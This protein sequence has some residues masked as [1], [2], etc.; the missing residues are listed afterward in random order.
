MEAP[1][2]LEVPSVVTD[3]SPGQH[4]GQAA[5]VSFGQPSETSAMPRS[6]A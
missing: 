1:V 4:S 5:G 6:A 2:S 3:D